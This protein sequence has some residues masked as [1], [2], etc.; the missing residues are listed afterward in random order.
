MG[1]AV[2]IVGMAEAMGGS[3]EGATSKLPQRQGLQCLDAD[4]AARGEAND[5][6]VG[7]KAHSLAVVAQ[8]LQ[9]KQR[10]HIAQFVISILARTHVFLAVTE[11]SA[12]SVQRQRAC[13]V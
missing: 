3:V 13:F 1:T 9:Q 2:V 7:P 8:D 5:G 10:H 12:L 4:H 6:V 11:F